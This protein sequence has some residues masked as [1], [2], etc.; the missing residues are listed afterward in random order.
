VLVV[1][2]A[3]NDCILILD[4][5]RSRRVDSA[6]SL[7]A[8]LTEI[9]DA[10]VS[11]YRVPPLTPL[12]VIQAL[13]ERELD[14]PVIVVSGTMEE[15]EMVEVVRAGAHDYMQKGNLKRLVPAI[16]R[17]L[18]E[19]AGRRARRQAER[20]ATESARQLEAV[21]DE[22]RDQ[23]E[24]VFGER[25]EKLVV[26]LA[27]QAAVAMDNA[28]LYRQAQEAN[29]MKDEF[30][31]TL[32]HELRTPMNAILDVSRI[33]SG[34]LR[35]DIRPVEP[36]RAVEAALDTVRPAAQARGIRLHTALDAGAGL[37]SGDADRLQQIV[38]NLLS[39]AIKFTPHGGHVSVRLAGVDSHVQLT[40][41]D[42]GIGID[43]DFL[44]HVF[45]R[46]RQGDS[47]STRPHGGLGLG[48]ALVRHLVELHGGTI[49]ASSPGRDQG[50]TFIV[51]LPVMGVVRPP[52]RELPLAAPGDMPAASPVG[53]LDG[54]NVLL[55]DD[56]ADARDL[57]KTLLERSGAHVTAVASGAEAFSAFT[58]RRRGE[59][60]R[61]AGG[62]R[63]RPHPPTARAAPR[64]R[65]PHP[66]RGAHGLMRGPRTACAPSA[67]A[68]RST[69]ASPC[70][71]PS[72]SPSWPAW[73]AAA[74]AQLRAERDSFPRS[75]RGFKGVRR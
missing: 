63:V 12:H 24:G 72:S 54:V 74:N 20:A 70:S 66:R 31:A 15:E 46:F 9:W 71:P 42:N 53:S 22:L 39:N 45:E 33:V 51:K 60:H 25:Q 34:K 47:S 73:S 55:V 68:S 36:V 32:S 64:A 18:A 40:V 35:L 59:R 5:L 52:A 29:R 4:E 65:G 58:A 13:R 2:D 21:F 30:L 48:L 56:E 10:V 23:K 28:R 19:A 16:R 14:A 57:F 61:D 67:P 75:E 3:E 17:E 41:A 62:E 49:Q 1:E 26:G 69:C 6:E 44:P 7:G 38:W 43:A 27:A 11:D 37:I 8:A 50:S